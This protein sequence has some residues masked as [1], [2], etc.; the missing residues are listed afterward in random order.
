MVG[1]SAKAECMPRFKRDLTLAKIEMSIRSQHSKEKPNMPPSRI[2][3]IAYLAFIPC[4][5]FCAESFTPSLDGKKLIGS[6]IYC[7]SSSFVRENIEELERLPFDGMII[8]R[9][10]PFW[11]GKKNE[12][13]L[14]EARCADMVKDPEESLDHFVAELKA[15]KFARFTDN[16]MG[17]ESSHE[18]D[19]DWFDEARC[20]QMAG[21]WGL[22]A[23]AAKEAGLK[24]LKFDAE[25]YQGD[26]LFVYGRD[27]LKSK[28]AY[29]ARMEEVGARVMREI[30]RHY[31]DMVL[32]L[33]LGHTAS[34]QNMTA[35]FLD[36][37]L[38]EAL[39]G[40][41]MVDG[42]EDAYGFR[43]KGQFK[44]GRRHM[45]ER[46]FRE[47]HFRPQFGKHVQAGFAVWPCNWQGKPPDRIS[48]NTHDFELNYYTPDEL[49]YTTQ[50][51]LSYSDKYVW[52]WGESLNVW[53]STVTVYD[54]DG[55]AET[56]PI[57]Q[58]YVEA[59]ARGKR[60][61]VPEPPSRDTSKVD[62][63]PR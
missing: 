46:A 32:L 24:G 51:A 62:P 27:N 55:N 31:P 54:K 38:S 40:F 26:D 34:W 59:L 47:S 13:R 58:E 3:I 10:W 36:G 49:A 18:G 45:K 2:L 7:R 44:E 57:P 8:G 9:F 41:V 39:P 56:G 52:V 53:K 23:K 30:N 11:A 1:Q 43:S 12:D 5:S 21:K 37:M 4:V 20:D 50:C 16:F 19:F 14:R 15:T 35:P 17:V 63:G 6:G 60:G 61:N 28:R 25:G 29:A 48:F 33:Y 42:Y 22:L